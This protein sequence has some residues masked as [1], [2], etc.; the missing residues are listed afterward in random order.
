ML[1]VLKLMPA[2]G[3]DLDY[4][5]WTGHSIF[6]ENKISSS[7]KKNQKTK[8]EKPGS[9]VCSNVLFVSLLSSVKLG[10]YCF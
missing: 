6:T 3:K 10:Y 9:A 1:A 4:T 2:E 5:E 8:P 7:K